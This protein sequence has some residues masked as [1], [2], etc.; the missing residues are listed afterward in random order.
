[1]GPRTRDGAARSIALRMAAASAVV[2]GAGAPALGAAGASPARHVPPITY[3][4]S[5]GDSLASGIGAS[6]PA[7]DYVDLPAAHEGVSQPGLTV[8]NVSCPG[9]TTTTVLDGGGI[10]SYPAGTQ[11]A[12]AE[13]FLTAHP[14]QVPYITIDIG[15]NNVDDCLTSGAISLT[16]VTAGLAGI[17]RELPQIIAGLRQAAPGVPIFGMD[18]YDPFLAEWVL[19]GPAGPGLARDSAFLSTLLNGSLTQIYGA[20]GAVPVDVQGP[21][22]TQDFAMTGSFKGTTV[23]ESVSRTCAWTHM[24]DSTGLTIH[25]ND[26]GHAKLAGAF[27]RTVDRALR[28]GGR[29]T[30]LADAAGGVHV[31]GNAG[32]FGSMA[33]QRL[34]RPVVALAATSDARGY[35]MIAADGGVFTFGDAGYFG[36]TGGLALNQ[37]IVGMAATSDDR[38]YWLVAADGGV[39]SFGDAP[40]LGSMGAVHLNQPVV[41][42][43]QT[44]S[45]RGYWLVAADGGAFSLGDAA[46]YGSMGAVHL[47]QPVVGMAATVDGNGYW[48]VAADGGVFTFGDG[49]FHGSTG[50][51]A[52]NRPIIGMAVTPDG[53]GYTMAASD[54]GLFTFG[55]AVFD[56]SL[57]GAPPVDPVVSGAST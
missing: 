43:A 11:L 56:G 57:G 38:G 51:L 12:Q 6:T 41:G 13:A 15:A 52:L 40:F 9:A 47:N 14:G 45:D 25:A 17:Q 8:Q 34:N 10:C 44:G 21:F 31:V 53:Y 39:F 29:G 26:I 30:G 1:M 16:C 35:W 37:P 36:S 55:R 54:G 48:L 49:L 24:C 4:L 3:Q 22:A 5:L 27:E 28:G 23:P 32:Q 2:L 33:G 46:F 50:G 7:D 18:Y 20:G 19:G 42:M